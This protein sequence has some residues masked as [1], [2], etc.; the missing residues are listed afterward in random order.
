MLYCRPKRLF[1]ENKQK[2]DLKKK[3]PLI[4]ASVERFC[5]NVLKRSTKVGRFSNAVIDFAYQSDSL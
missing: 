3:K 5:N 2:K 4:F 1:A